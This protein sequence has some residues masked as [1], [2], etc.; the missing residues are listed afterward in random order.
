MV[1]KDLDSRIRKNDQLSVTVSTAN[2]AD[3]TLFNA[4]SALGTPTGGI[5]YVV[6]IDGNIDM[7]KLGKVHVEGL[8]RKELKGK[9]QQD[10]APYVKDPVIVVNFLN[11]RITVLGDVINPSIVPMTEDQLSLLDALAATGDMRVTASRTNLLIIRTTDTGKQ[12]KRINLEDHSLFSTDSSWYYLQPDDI[13]YVV[14]DFEKQ[15][16][17]EK[18]IRNQQL[19]ATAIATTSVLI[20]L[21]DRIIK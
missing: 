13:V 9:L 10:L 3:N 5:G 11:H 7:Y 18:R 19:L 21:I 4:P 2:P 6:D 8:T 20:I 12:F 16:R 17:N 15:E 14:P 1:N